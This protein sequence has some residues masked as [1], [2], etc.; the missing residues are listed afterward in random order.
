MAP[1][2]AAVI[3]SILKGLASSALA[4]TTAAWIADK[5]GLPEKT[6]EAVTN[7]INGL[8]PA[9]QIKMKEMEY[10]FQKF[11]ADNGIKLDLAQ[12]Q[13]NQEEAKNERLFVSGWRPAVGWIGA[14]S[15]AYV[16]IVE[17]LLRFIASV[18]FSYKGAFPVIDTSIT[19]Q[20]LFGILGL[21]AL[22]SYD[23]KNGKPNG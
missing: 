4:D 5:L 1:L 12:I 11:M 16:S 18:M 19:M 6:V 8:T 2:I 21:G 3:P 9:D 10:E 7:H 14:L 15:L 20:I 23:K 13:V 17:P 22:R